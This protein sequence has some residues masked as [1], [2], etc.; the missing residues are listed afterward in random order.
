MNGLELLDE[1]P[2]A[3]IVIKQWYLD[4]MLESLRDEDL[5]EDFKEH[6]RQQG[7]T[8]EN[9]SKML[10]GMPRALFD[11]FDSHKI[12]IGTI[13]DEN[14]GFWWTINDIKSTVG[15]EYR[16][17]CEIAAIKEAFKL[18]NDKL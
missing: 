16:K 6:V 8:N 18:L 13:L 1:Y 3:A 7:I 4:K 2:K 14:N 12:Y 17:N 11:V 15:Y 10:E 9:V 5:P